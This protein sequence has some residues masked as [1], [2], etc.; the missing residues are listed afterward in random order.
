[1]TEETLQ[2]GFNWVCKEGYSWGSIAKRVFHPQQR[3]FTR[4][5]SNIAYRN[6]IRRTPEASIPTL[7]KSLQ[8]MNDTIPLRSTRD[9]VQRMGEKIAEKR[10]LLGQ[11][12]ADALKLYSF[13]NERLRTL[14]VRLEGSI[15]REGAKELAKRL[16]KALGA[17][18]DQVILDFKDVVAFST[19]A[20][21]LLSRKGL[22]KTEEGHLWMA[23]NVPD[24]M[25]NIPI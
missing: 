9:L 11:K 13:Y 15:D 12:A 19:E 6:I 1:M 22:L 18:I 8:K 5:L 4:V 7:S 23:V 21:A 24:Q 17:E 10:L 25:L 20:M 3:F 2:Q 16:E 14:F